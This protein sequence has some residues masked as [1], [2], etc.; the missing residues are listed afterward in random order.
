MGSHG[1]IWQDW[2][3]QEEVDALIETGLWWI[4]EDGK[5]VPRISGDGI[6]LDNDIWYTTTNAAG[7]DTVNMFKVNTDDEIDVGATLNVGTIESAT[8][9]GATV[10][11]DMT[12]TS[13]SP[14]DTEQST[15][16]NIDGNNFI[17]FYSESDGAGGIQNE[18]IELFNEVYTSTKIATTT[19]ES[20]TTCGEVTL[21]A[22]SS[23]YINATIL[24]RETDGS[25]HALYN[26]E[27]LFYHEAGDAIQEGS[28]TSVTTIESAGA[29]GWSCEFTPNSDVVEVTVSGIAATTIDWKTVLEFIRV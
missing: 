6:K 1:N 11:H 16:I 19:N 14:V 5:L 17:K 24:G 23:Y 18:R 7:D 3:T 9:S 12:V 4:R 28:T 27:G 10:L 29:S 22:T 21:D 20:A 15:S 25:N 8:D 2:Y 13:G 26:L